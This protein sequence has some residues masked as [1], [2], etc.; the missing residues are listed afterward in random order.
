MIETDA[1]LQPMPDCIPGWTWEV[2]TSEIRAAVRAA[3][4]M[5]DPAVARIAK[6]KRTG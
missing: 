5:P 3:A 1:D 2:V 4:R 6:E